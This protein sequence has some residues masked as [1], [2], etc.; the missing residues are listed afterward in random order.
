MQLDAIKRQRIEGRL[1]I[2]LDASNA[3][4]WCLKAMKELKGSI[5]IK[6][7]QY[8]VRNKAIT[9]I[10]ICSITFPPGASV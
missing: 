4:A 8:R 3:L 7:A 2:F 6:K 1:A 9:N 5:D 10:S